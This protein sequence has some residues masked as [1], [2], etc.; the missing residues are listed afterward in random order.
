MPH[1]TAESVRKEVKPYT[2]EESKSAQ[3]EAMFDSISHRYDF[4]NHFLSFGIDKKWRTAVVKELRNLQPKKI[5][6]VATGTGDLAIA[7]L[8]L[9]PD[10]ITGVDLSANMLEVGRKKIWDSGIKNIELEKGDSM[11]L[12]YADNSYDAVTVAYGVRNFEDLEKGL[13]EMLRV[14]RSGGRLVILEFSKPSTFP[15]K[16]LYGF[17]SRYLLPMWGKLFSGNADAYRYLPE[18]VQHFPEGNELLEILKKC[19]YSDVKCRRLTF[20]ISSIY[21]ATK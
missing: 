5:L 7:C 12:K 9:K 15:M 10:H 6:D 8:D 20:G 18:S 19:G 13:K 4:L 3:I 17:Y 14:L 2:S 21:V 16:Q 11:N 1:T